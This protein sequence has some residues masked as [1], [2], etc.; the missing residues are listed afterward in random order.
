[1][2][3]LHECP[4]CHYRFEDAEALDRHVNEDAGCPERA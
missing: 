3:G 2:P 4:D 1:M